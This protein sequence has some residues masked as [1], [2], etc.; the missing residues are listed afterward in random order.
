MKEIISNSPLARRRILIK[1]Y[2]SLISCCLM[3]ISVIYFLVYGIRHCSRAKTHKT[4]THP[5]DSKVAFSWQG[6]KSKS[7]VLLCILVCRSTLVCVS[8]AVWVEGTKEEKAAAKSE[9]S[10]WHRTAAACFQRWPFSLKFNQALAIFVMF[11][12][13]Q[14]NFKSFVFNFLV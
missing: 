2:F 3:F 14:L 5:S 1:S 4:H 12:K 9:L 8:E 6:R 13:C 10:Q 11:A 7:G